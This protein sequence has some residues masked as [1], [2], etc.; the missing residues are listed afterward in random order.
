MFGNVLDELET[1]RQFNLLPNLSLCLSMFEKFLL[2][3]KH[4]ERFLASNTGDAS[5][6]KRYFFIVTQASRK[7][8]GFKRWAI[9]KK[10]SFVITQAYRKLPSFKYWDTAIPKRYFFIITQ[11]YRKFSGFKFWGCCYHKQIFL[12]LSLKHP[13]SSLV[14]NTED[15]AIPKICFP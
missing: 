13:E 11:A 6:T 9:S 5:I 4:P 12:L 3:L 10:C 1:D 14:S 7:L 15:A 2:L 8:P